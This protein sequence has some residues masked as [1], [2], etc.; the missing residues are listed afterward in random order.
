MSMAPSDI[1]RRDA[2]VAA[3]FAMAL[4]YLGTGP[5]ESVARAAAERPGRQPRI[6]H[7]ERLVISGAITQA[8]PRRRRR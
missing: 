3:A 8:A 4:N 6:P 5:F 7:F 2:D 1:V